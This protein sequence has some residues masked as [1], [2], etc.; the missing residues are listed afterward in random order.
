M[1]K[2]TP[3][4]KYI[5]VEEV[6]FLSGISE[7]TYIKIGGTINW[8]FDRENKAYDFKFIGNFRPIDGGEDTTRGVIWPVEI[9][10]ITGSLAV[11]GVA[12]NTIVDLHLIRNGVDLGSLWST[13]L[14]IANSAADGVTFGENYPDGTDLNPAGVTLPVFNSFNLNQFDALRVDL[15]ANATGACNLALNI[16]YRPR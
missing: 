7:R 6:D 12:N 15:D 14:Q 13:K 4:K 10:G 2:I 3:E 1:T 11:T 5:Q 8:I 16:H 9:V